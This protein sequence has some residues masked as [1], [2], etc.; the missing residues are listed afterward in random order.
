M[1]SIE[2]ASGG[3]LATPNGRSSQIAANLQVEPLY[4]QSGEDLPGDHTCKLKCLGQ[5]TTTIKTSEDETYGPS[6]TYPTPEEAFKP[7]LGYPNTEGN[8]VAKTKKTTEKSTASDFKEEDWLRARLAPS[9][10]PSWL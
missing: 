10:V 1:P 5:D 9:H 4:A 7:Y 2:Y 3:Y 6:Y 8:Q